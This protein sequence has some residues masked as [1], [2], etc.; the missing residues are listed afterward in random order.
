MPSKKIS[1]K[2]AISLIVSYVLLIGISIAIGGSIYVWL[3]YY[4]KA[5]FPEEP[6]PE[7]ISL[8]IHDYDCSISEIINLTVQN[9]GRWNVSGYVAKFNNESGGIAGKFPLY[10]NGTTTNKVELNIGP[11]ERASELFNYSGYAQ[12]KQIEIEPFIIRNGKMALCPKAIA[13]QPIT[14]P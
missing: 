9:K 8:I 12:I 7:G 6:C 10:I 14:C 2:K 3:R 5:P 13:Q 4:T 1:Q 11:G